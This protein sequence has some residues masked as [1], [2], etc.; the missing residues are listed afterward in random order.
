MGENW[1]SATRHDGEMGR[2]IEPRR[3]EDVPESVEEQR[4][5]GRTL[6]TA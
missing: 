3:E 6:K 5:A 4:V 2:I 1:K